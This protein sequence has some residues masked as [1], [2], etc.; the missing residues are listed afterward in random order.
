MSFQLESL[1]RAV[2]NAWQARELAVV[3]ERAER[4]KNAAEAMAYLRGQMDR[5]DA[6]MA[7][8]SSAV[9]AR[10]GMKTLANKL[11]VMAETGQG[12]GLMCGLKFID[13]R[14]HGAQ[15]GSVIVIGARS[16][17]GKSLVANNVALG[18]ARKNPQTK[19]VVYNMEMQPDEVLARM[20]SATALTWGESVQYREFS[21]PK[22][23]HA[24]SIADV[25]QEMP[26]NLIIDGGYS[27]TLD[28]IKS[29]A[30]RYKSAGD[31]GMIVVDYVGLVDL[32]HMGSGKTYAQQLA[33]MTAEFKRMASQLNCCIVLVAQ[34]NRSPDS[35]DN[36]RPTMSDIRDSGG[37]EQDAS[38]VF[39]PYREVY[40][41]QNEEPSDPG[42]VIE[43]KQ[44]CKRLAHKLVMICAKNRNGERGDDEMWVSLG[45][46]LLLNEKPNWWRGE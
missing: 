19:V 11:A 5:I 35:R 9:S 16:S 17:M 22:H 30:W 12:A 20:A 33:G 27:L 7:Q 34:L 29:D 44:E 31:L 37:F 14:L 15:R 38:V 3:T 4:M 36:K 43:W 13:D 39:L 25:A 21:Q 23:E 45:H 42:D 1:A 41:L 28:K 32:G 18:T 46:D 24:R 2:V 10:D 8:K 26:E 6:D 40:Y